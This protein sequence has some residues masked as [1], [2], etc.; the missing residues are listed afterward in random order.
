MGRVIARYLFFILA[1]FASIASFSQS[2]VLGKITNNSGETLPGVSILLKNNEGKIVTYAIATSEG[3][4]TLI[5]E[6]GSYSIEANLLGY[7][8]QSLNLTIGN[9]QK[10]IQDFILQ[11]FGEE[12]KEVIIE[13]EQP[14]KL[15]GDTLVFDAKSYTKGTEAVVEDLLKNI[16][17]ITIAKDGTIR[18]N[19]K[20]IEKIMVEGDDL[21]NKGYSI[22]TR[23]M[24]NKP[25]DKVEVLQNYSSNKLLKGIEESSAVALN[26]TLQDKYKSLWFGN[27]EVGYGERNRYL[28]NGSLMNFTNN[29]KTFFTTS[30][31]NAGYDRIGN[32]DAMVSN[33]VDLE[34]IGYG[35]RAAQVMNIGF[36]VPRLDEERARFNNA[37]MATLSTIFPL[38][39]KGKLKLLGFMGFDEQDAYQ[40][41]FSVTDFN[42]TYFE[43]T[44]VNDSRNKISR[45]FTNALIN[46]DLSATQMLQASTTISGGKSNFRNN[47]IF[48]G[49]GTRETLETR[50]TYFDQKA[51]Y[52]HKWKERNV[53]LFKTR[54]FTDRLPQN[55]G[56]NDYLLG[57]LFQYE[58]ITA[59]GNDA[60]ASKE[61]AGV[62]A[63]FKLKQKNGDLI[64]FAVGLDHNND[65]LATTFS[66][67][68]E[69]ATITPEGYQS[70]ATFRTDDIYA[71]SG[72]SYKFKDVSLGASVDVHQ[73][74]NYFENKE[75]QIKKQNPFLVNPSL[76]A[77]WQIKPDNTVGASYNY[78]ISNTDLL[79]VND[80]YMLTSSRGFSRGL[81]YFSQLQSSST[82]LYF[83]TKHYLNRYQFSFG[84]DYSKQN[85]V[86]AYRSLLDQ[87]TSLSE[88]FI[89]EG[90]N[91]LGARI[92]GHYIVRPLKGTI[93]F[94]ADA[95]RV[96]YF[97]RINNSGLRQ[98]T[99]YNQEF[100][101]GW[102]SNFKG[103]FNF[104]CETQWDYLQVKSDN[105]FKNTTK[106]SFINI[107]Y[108]FSERFN[109]QLN[110]E[111][112]NFGGMDRYNNY[113]FSDLTARYNF[114]KDKYSIGI[115]ARNLFD[116]K[117]FTT[118]N[119]SDIGYS[120]NQYRLLP[121]YTMLSFKFRF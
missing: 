4:Y 5:L 67:Y 89:M 118:Y 84:L 16:P 120:V 14:V 94:A 41:R 3:T 114:A 53:V 20:P 93:K 10:L 76:Y 7:K 42:G 80:A 103:P 51:T 43:N 79:Q 96:V 119:V 70:D 73:F 87:N 66:L 88:A 105:T 36:K 33:S 101:F 69:G 28:A 18:Y 72:Y 92:S 115:D 74:Y 81:G 83:T 102:T 60:K 85:D 17:G 104:N 78:N 100:V 49:T 108:V 45:T 22:L 56:I 113:F 50:N 95:G 97:N 8:K 44:E 77:T 38:G 27:I 6:E 13:Y 106:Y 12:L 63:D 19:D 11:P 46:Y 98:N 23:N 82:S 21:F 109:L 9:N 116:T 99:I 61:Y 26:L 47:Y 55:Y 86:I 1:L 59:I 90:G 112:Y 40:D 48:N 62:Q 25:L 24:P 15:R 37:E 68:N 31:N 54:F 57:D 30:F 29:Y 52:T 35:Y 121:R 32:P 64:N 91:R 110:T 65:N 58:G 2:Q 39:D 75:G 117:S 111:H 34:S 71:K 107:Q